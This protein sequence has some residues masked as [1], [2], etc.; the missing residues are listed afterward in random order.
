MKRREF[1]KQSAAFAAGCMALPEFGRPLSSGRPDLAVVSNGEPAELVRAAVQALGGIES[2][3]S[4]GD[5]VALKVNMSWDRIP[6]QAANTNPEIVAE[7]VRL[8][9]AAGARRVAVFDRTLND[10]K[11][12]YHRSGIEAAA[13]DAGAHVFYM[14]PGRYTRVRFPE[15][16][17]LKSWEIYR[18]ALE[19]DTI[20]NIPVAKHHSISGVSL[21]MK[22]F[23]GWIGGDRGRLHRNFSVKLTD[24]N[25]VIK[26]DLTILDAYRMLVRNGPSGGN[27]AD[28][29][30]P[31]TVVAG[32]NVVS[33]DSYGARLFNRNPAELPFLAEAESRGLGTTD[34]DSI[35]IKEITLNA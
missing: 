29:T 35:I 32:T 22:N 15:A 30:L 34:L 11:R 26:A 13:K 1:L 23:M 16:S 18:D 12:C 31:K 8:C 27:P 20:I 7:V 2:F 14:H 21:G 5:T 19:A 10:A 17:A 28:V 33:V 9:R 4:R 3:I 25:T 6:A 24:L